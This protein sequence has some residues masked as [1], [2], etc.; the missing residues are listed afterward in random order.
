MRSSSRSSNMANL[1][2]EAAGAALVALLVAV[3]R[4]RRAGTMAEVP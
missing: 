1:G 4:R 3:G 2:R